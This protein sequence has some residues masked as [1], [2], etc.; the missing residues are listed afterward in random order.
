MRRLKRS[1]ESL[2]DWWEW[3]PEARAKLMEVCEG[4]W[5]LRARVQ[6]W[7]WRDADD[8]DAGLMAQLLRD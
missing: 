7:V 6:S 4:P 2:R 3:M 8:A 5:L 1:T